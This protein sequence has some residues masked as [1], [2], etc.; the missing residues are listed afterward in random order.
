MGEVEEWQC[1]L[2]LD[3]MAPAQP[4][5][6]STFRLRV[7]PDGG[8]VGFKE[9]PM[10]DL[11]RLVSRT[12]G[13]SDNMTATRMFRMAGDVWGEYDQEGIRFT[14]LTR[15]KVGRYQF[16][17]KW[18]TF[19]QSVKE[20]NCRFGADLTQDA[21]VTTLGTFQLLKVATDST[22]AEES[23]SGSTFC[24]N[25]AR[26]MATAVED[27]K[28]YDLMINTRDGA[29]L[30]AHKL[31]LAS[32]TSYFE[33]LFRQENPDQVSL[34]FER[35]IVQKCL[36]YLYTGIIVVEGHDVQDIL[37]CANYLAIQDVVDKCEAFIVRNLD[38]T[39]CLE[40]LLFA[41]QI[42]SR[43]VMKAALD[44][45][46]KHFQALA[47][48]PSLRSLPVHLHREILK[49]DSLALYSQ[50]GTLLTDEFR[51]DAL[52]K[53]L[54][55]FE[56]IGV[57]EEGIVRRGEDRVIR[58]SGKGVDYHPSNLAV[59]GRPGN[60][61]LTVENFKVDA[62]DRLSPDFPFGNSIRG[63]MVKLVEWDGRQVVGGIVLFWA[64]GHQDRFGVEEDE[65]EGLRLMEVPEGSHIAFVLGRS[66]WY[67]DNLTFVLSTGRVLGGE[68]HIGGDGGGLKHSLARLQ[69]KFN[70]T[71]MHLQGVKGTNVRSQ[72][73]ALITNVTFLYKV[74]ADEQM[75]SKDMES[76]EV[77]AYSG[78]LLEALESDDG[79]ESNYSVDSEHWLDDAEDFFDNEYMEEEEIDFED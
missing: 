30:P 24:N 52:E 74:A 4:P 62:L 33:G 75:E 20:G 67:V 28:F 15:E 39:N 46:S 69:P 76:S 60:P 29:Q 12:H 61:H 13:M 66:G 41:D 38:T 57:R 22:K 79:G 50:F 55:R 10:A 73:V 26:Y 8:L 43:K 58:E 68:E 44:F 53:H 3:G 72:G 19:M 16:Q 6:P 47:T 14:L 7:S 51:E 65:V 78:S 37:T 27:K 9:R 64:N 54:Q 35:T 2:S 21:V 31:V 48:L 11:D 77:R 56:D 63:V 45:S 34:N 36:D 71:N 49:S 23:F 42:S 59:F 5:L 32:Q 18:S 70:V 25:L 1:L 17:G 40:V